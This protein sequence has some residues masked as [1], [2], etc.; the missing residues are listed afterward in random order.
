MAA[1]LVMASCWSE[2]YNRY[3]QQAQYARTL[4][5][6]PVVRPDASRHDQVRTLR[7][8]AYA[9]AQYRSQVM[10]WEARLGL[11][12]AR[13]NKVI[14]PGF[15]IEL[16]LVDTK[17]WE[18]AAPGNDLF[19]ALAELEQLDPA[20]DV[21]WVIGLVT[22]L[23][24]V[25]SS[26]HQ[27][28]A[29]RPLS[30]YMV[31]RS[32]NDVAERKTIDEVFDELDDDQR[33][34]LFK[35]RKAHKELVLFIHE[36]AHTLG[37]VHVEQPTAI[38]NP[39]YHHRVGKLT[40]PNAALM[41]IALR[42]RGRGELSGADT[43]KMAEEMLA[44]LRAHEK[45]WVPDEVKALIQVLD[46]APRV[47]VEQRRT[48]IT[49]ALTPAG[50][51]EFRRAIDLA[52][53]GAWTGAYDAILPLTEQYENEPEVMLA[54]CRIAARARGAGYPTN[55]LCKRASELAPADATPHLALAHIHFAAK[56]DA[57]GLEQ[58]RRGH[59]ALASAG[60]AASPKQWLE[61]A[62]QYQRLG[63][64]TWMD[65]A[66]A[67][68]GDEPRAEAM[69]TWVT[70]TR[71]RYAIPPDGEPFGVPPA[72][73]GE[74]LELIKEVLSLTYAGKYKSASEAADRALAAFP[75]SPGVAVAL[76]DFNLRIGKTRVARKLCDRAI[77]GYDDAMWA[78][79][80]VGGIDA[81]A[82][83]NASAIRHLT[84]AIELDPDMKPLWELLAKVYR[85]AGKADALRDLE[86]RYRD[87][88]GSAL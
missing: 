70:Q 3:Q 22:Q 87:R 19:A 82:K 14:G 80:L 13:V 6:A 34:K 1:G 30:R 17:P 72:R 46:S 54:G 28:G 38:L 63:L 2:R 65:E 5:P 8:R 73:D 81:R 55:Q 83:R 62:T 23:P 26:I 29:A 61:I 43:A 49:A 75:K 18:R 9:D 76:C 79:Y 37:A 86:T 32:M 33:E 48:K 47:A 53:Q 77:A 51:R 74:H 45:H 57:N 85:A 59:A 20:D 27:L 44:Y 60:E 41:E 50:R 56:D 35:K 4:E 58:L 40:A 21:D 88:F 69:R 10:R 7:V 31:L 64:I 25:S 16:E 84:R 15:G 68:A 71:R 36:W 12:I 39:S 11:L 67:G 24:E 66:L 52:D 42:Y 78:H